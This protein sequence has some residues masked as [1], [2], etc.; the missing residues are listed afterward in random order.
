MLHHG[1]L[2]SVLTPFGARMHVAEEETPKALTT[3]DG[4][5]IWRSSRYRLPVGGLGGEMDQR[6]GGWTGHQGEKSL[7]QLKPHDVDEL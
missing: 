7:I 5:A 1:G 2:S 3:N 4:R 6:T